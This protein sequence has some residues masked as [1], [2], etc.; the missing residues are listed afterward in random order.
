M[1]AS[2]VGSEMCI[3]DSL[4]GD[5]IPDFTDVAGE[6]GIAGTNK[7]MGTALADYDNDGDL[8]ILMAHSDRPVIL[9]RN[10]AVE[11]GTGAW[12]KVRLHGTELGSNSH[13][14]GCLVKVHL[15][16]GTVLVQHAYAGDGFLGSSD[17][18]IHFGLGNQTIEYLEVTWSTG[19]TQII[20]EVEINSV[21]N[22]EEELPPPVKDLS[23]YILAVLSL[24]LILLLWPL[25]QRNS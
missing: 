17:P 18:A 21:L 5:G 1:S 22:V 8:D 19:H 24:I 23:A 12:L 13:G 15:E 4:N 2:L 9:W 25:L 10:T 14:I 16:D 20:E 7:T 3:R 11:D 6:L